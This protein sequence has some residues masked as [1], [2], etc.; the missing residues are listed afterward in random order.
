MKQDLEAVI[1]VIN[2]Y[3]NKNKANAPESNLTEKEQ[4]KNFWA[5]L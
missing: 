2:Y 4:D 3:L 5:A 1:M